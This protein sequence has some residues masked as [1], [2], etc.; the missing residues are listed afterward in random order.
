[1]LTDLAAKG[2]IP[3]KL[4]EMTTL[5][6]QIGNLGAHAAQ[7]AV[8]PSQVPAIDQFFRAVVEYVYV[9]PFRVSEF[10]RAMQGADEGIL[11]IESDT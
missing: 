1:M 2:E 7:Q 4:A 3:S 10:Q 9:A 6:R 11:S 5:L 8:K